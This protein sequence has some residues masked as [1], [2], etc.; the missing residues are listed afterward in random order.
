M[1]LCKLSELPEETVAKLVKGEEKERTHLNAEIK[2]LKEWFRK[3]GMETTIV[4]RRLRSIVGKGKGSP[5]ELHRSPESVAI[6][7]IARE[8][9]KSD[10]EKIVNTLHFVLLPQ[11][12]VR[13]ANG[14]TLINI[15]NLNKEVK[16]PL[17]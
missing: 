6:F 9:V 14:G 1:A 5:K 12:P 2:N 16:S 11:N 3:K 7:K 13:D 8:L 17:G 15:I 10:G 4:R